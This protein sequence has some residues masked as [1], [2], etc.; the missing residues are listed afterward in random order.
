M[1]TA[2][3]APDQPIDPPEAPAPQTKTITVYIR[4]AGVCKKEIEVPIDFDASDSQAVG[5]ALHEYT[6]EHRPA[7]AQDDPERWK[8]WNWGLGEFFQESRNFNDPQPGD[9][10]RI[11]VEGIEDEA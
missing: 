3:I 6:S 5:D 10:A 4:F 1:Q 2:N 8:F 11:F 7:Y 9:E